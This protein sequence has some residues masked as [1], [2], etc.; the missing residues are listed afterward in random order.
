MS[1]ETF[2]RLTLASPEGGT[3]ERSNWL[4][5]GALTIQSSL[6]SGLSRIPT[7]LS[8]TRSAPCSAARYR[9][10]SWMWTRPL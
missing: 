6:P 9:A 2:T 1:A 4:L 8:L 3:E 10:T 5:T 7:T